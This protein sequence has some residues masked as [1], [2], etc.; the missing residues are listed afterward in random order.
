M[1]TEEVQREKGCKIKWEMN[2][3][4]VYTQCR[5]T[6]SSFKG[7]FPFTESHKDPQSLIEPPFRKGGSFI[8][9]KALKAHPRLELLYT[10]S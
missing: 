6:T 4:K 9:T 3:T 2:R 5:A 7:L 1:V 10:S 8:H